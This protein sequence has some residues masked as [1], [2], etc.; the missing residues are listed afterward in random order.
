MKKEIV[1]R[2]CN[3]TILSTDIDIVHLNLHLGCALKEET[4]GKD[5]KEQYLEASAELF[6]EDKGANS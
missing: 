4:R 1:C 5:I 3:K 6:K 2:V